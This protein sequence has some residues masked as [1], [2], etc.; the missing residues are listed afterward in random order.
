MSYMRPTKNVH[1]FEILRHSDLVICVCLALV[2]P[3]IY[4]KYECSMI[5]YIGRRGNNSKTE[6]RL[7]LGHN[8]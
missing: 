4:V 1:K 7:P 2:L 5:S 8:I 6:K 3:Y